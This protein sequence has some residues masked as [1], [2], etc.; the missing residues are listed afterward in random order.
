[1]SAANPFRPTA[2]AVTLLLAI[3]V[4]TAHATTWTDWTSATS[5]SA[6]GMVGNVAV[7]FS[8]TAGVWGWQT[9]GGTNFYNG[10]PIGADVPDNTDILMLGEGGTRTITFGQAVTSVTLALV[11]WNVGGTVTFDKPFSSAAIGCGYWGCGSITPVNGNTGFT[12]QG[13]VHGTLSFTGPIT[14]LTFSDG[15]EYWHG[16]TVGVG[17]PVPEPA[18]YALMALGLVA[19][20]SLARRRRG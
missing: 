3:A 5:S 8:S 9:D 13:E 15:S 10:W 18:T 20:G 17:A 2:A 6:I 14:S 4:P 12:A 16:I 7:S 19:V 11:S 1:M